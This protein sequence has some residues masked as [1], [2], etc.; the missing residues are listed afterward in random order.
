MVEWQFLKLKEKG[1]LT[2]GRHP[3]GWC[4]NDN[5]AVGQHDTK[6]DVQPEIEEVTAVKFKDAGSNAFFACATYRPETLYGVT[7]LFVNENV[8]Y[9]LARFKRQ[10]PITSQR[11]LQRC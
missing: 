6:H 2:Q 3:V 10:E 9:V 8:E 11:M 5:N 4:P 1:L 7:N